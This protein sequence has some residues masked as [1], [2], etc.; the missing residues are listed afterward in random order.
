MRILGLGLRQS[1]PWTERQ[2]T[3]KTQRQ[4][5]KQNAGV[6]SVV[7]LRAYMREGEGRN[8]DS[9]LGLRQAKQVM[10]K[11]RDRDK[12]T[13]DKKTA[14]QI[15]FFKHSIQKYTSSSSPPPPL[16]P[17]TPKS[18]P[19]IHVLCALLAQNVQRNGGDYQEEVRTFFGGV[20]GGGRQ[21]YG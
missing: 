17:F 4:R 3:K 18:I 1:Q 2:E 15:C 16:S 7:R 21:G 19:S 13:K 5:Q 8:E 14:A 9:G 20:A 11:N 6:V 12:D 10:D